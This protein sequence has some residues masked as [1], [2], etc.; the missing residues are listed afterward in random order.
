MKL[1]Y[2]NITAVFIELKEKAVILAALRCAVCAASWWH[3]I[4]MG[5]DRSMISLGWQ[6]FSLH[7]KLMF[8]YSADAVHVDEHLTTVLPLFLDDSEGAAF[9]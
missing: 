5:F 6:S 9:Q 7:A 1:L 4:L 2:V 8:R 3:V